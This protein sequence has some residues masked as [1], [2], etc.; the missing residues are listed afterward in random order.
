MPAWETIERMSLRGGPCHGEVLDAPPGGLEPVMSVP[1][2]SGKVAR[3]R[4]SGECE[5][6]RGVGMTEPFSRVWF[7][8]WSS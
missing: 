5:Q 8:D 2:P 7:Y 1:T 4:E 3:Y 6:L